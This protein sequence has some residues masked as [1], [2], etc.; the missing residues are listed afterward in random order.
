MLE[1]IGRL[2]ISDADRAAIL[3]RNAAK[4]LGRG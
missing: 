2:S 1:S 4:L 3:G